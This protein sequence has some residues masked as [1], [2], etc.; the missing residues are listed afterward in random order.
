MADGGERILWVT[1]RYPPD[2]G[3]MAVS[4][5]RQVRGLRE[6]DLA[7]D[8]FVLGG[9]SEEPGVRATSRDG[10]NDYRVDLAPDPGS[11]AQLAWQVMRREHAMRGYTRVVGFGAGRPG[12]LAVTVAAWL[13]LPAAVLVRGNDFD[14]DW[15]DPRRGF[16]VREALARAGAVGAVSSEK[17][18][19]IRALFPGKQVV[20]TPNG[21]EAARAEL[22]PAERAECDQVRAELAAGGRRV[23]GLFGELKFK[24]RTP[25]LLGALRDAG[26]VERSALL[27]VGRIDDQLRALLADPALSPRHHR[28]AFVEP[29]KLAGLYAACDFIALPSLFEGMPNVLLE[30]MVAG[31][32]PIVSDAGAMGQV[33]ADGRTGFVFATEDRDAA[34][35]CLDRAFALSD[36]QLAAMGEAAR[37][38]VAEEFSPQRE[39]D[40]LCELLNVKAEG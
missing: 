25:L 12:H 22:L 11:A 3:G 23:I 19:R 40:V 39:L 29:G 36:E 17:V 31:A 24:K 4:C 14:R 28:V 2:R 5:E 15:F 33:V 16:F 6:R 30:A 7:L 20:W 34:A 21:I 10:G 13:G 32:V 35:A 1:E 18:E 8:V 38:L 27:I 37:K 9:P 26:L